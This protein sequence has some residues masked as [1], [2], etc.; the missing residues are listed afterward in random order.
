[1]RPPMKRLLAALLVTVGAGVP[2]AAVD[3]SPPALSLQEC[4]GLALES[5]LQHL[6]DRRELERSQAVVR[7][8]RAPFELNA[9]ADLT[10]PHYDETRDTFEN[11]ALLSRVREEN[12][13]FR[14]RGRLE[15]SQRVR[16]VGRFSVSSVGLRQ[17]FNSNRRQDVLDYT[18]A[19]QF[20]YD[21][22]LL[23]TPDDETELAQAELLLATSRSGFRRQRLILEDDV[24]GFYYNLVES[25][26][27]L[28]IQKQRLEQAKA[29]V[30]LAERKYEIGLIAEVEALKLL[31]ERLDAEASF[32]QAETEIE[33][34]RDL[35]RQVL[36]MGM[37]EPLVVD[38]TVTY[39]LVTIDES[40]AVEVGLRERTDLRDAEID[41]RLRKLDLE[42]TKSRVGP[43]AAL[44][45]GVTLRGRGSGPEEIPRTFE[46]SVIS[47]RI[48]VGLPLL[49]GGGRRGAIRR[50][51]I[52]LEQGRLSR[53][54][55]RQ[56]VIVGIRN[57]VRNVAEAE[58][59]IGLRGST[60]DVAE[61][62]YAVERARF[63]LGI[64]ASRELLDAQTGVTSARIERL[65]AI[66]S[67]QRAL[68]K[69]RLVTMADLP[70]L[71]GRH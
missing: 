61:R 20:D 44:K 21:Q 7:E 51:E 40:R 18:G 9:R 59:Q 57:A 41:Q 48:D 58:R 4:I 33:R 47:A 37:T 11:V 27:R 35:L 62:Q 28:D 2:A 34:N 50:A 53:E 29:S 31:V 8:A 17:Q 65:N 3:T 36:G 49:D 70:E 54:M 23:S 30:E 55:Q 25:I 5:N 6:N 12:T 38:T 52:S 66:I 67:Y 68:G 14:Y 42:R 64:G 71:V 19:V 22:D 16:H 32:A 43:S 60:L 10:L 46:R 15:L 26:R 45:A 1:M 63:E 39:E 69:L 56:Q 13:D 24:T